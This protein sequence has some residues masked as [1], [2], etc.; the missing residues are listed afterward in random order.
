[1]HT[2]HWSGTQEYSFVLEAGSRLSLHKPIRRSLAGV[3][4]VKYLSMATL[5][6]L[7]SWNCLFCVADAQAAYLMT[8][9]G[10]TDGV[11]RVG[12]WRGRAAQRTAAGYARTRLSAWRSRVNLGVN[13][14]SNRCLYTTSISEK[15]VDKLVREVAEVCGIALTSPLQCSKVRGKLSNYSSCIQRSRPFVV[16]FSYFIG[17]PRNNHEWDRLKA[18]TEE[19]LNAASFLLKHMGT[20]VRLGSRS[21]QLGFRSLRLIL[22]K[23]LPDTLQSQPE[24][25]HRES[26]DEILH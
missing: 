5:S 20:L 24:M 10:G 14:N 22:L 19:M 3:G 4:P 11:C 2:P 23:V 17:G 13:I 25:V 26:P 9:L 21:G 7:L 1:M 15:K 6:L 18:I 16:P 8:L 12:R